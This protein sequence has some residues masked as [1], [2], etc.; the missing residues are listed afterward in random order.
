LFWAVVGV[1][2]VLI[3]TVLVVAR[4]EQWI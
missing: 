1:M 4:R 2:S 3:T